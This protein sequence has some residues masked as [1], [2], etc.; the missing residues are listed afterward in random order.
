MCMLPPQY[1]RMRFQ[2]PQPHIP[3]NKVHHREQQRRQQNLPSNKTLSDFALSPYA[4]FMSQKEKDWLVKI[5]LLQS[6]AT[7]NTHED[8]FYYSVSFLNHCYLFFGR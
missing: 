7:G 3:Q 4:G 8:D 1:P 6:A 2:Q 5:Q